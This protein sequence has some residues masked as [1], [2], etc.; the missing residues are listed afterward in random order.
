[1]G[2]SNISDDSFFERLAGSRVSACGPDQINVDYWKQA[3]GPI[4]DALFGV[5]VELLAGAPV[6]AG[7][8]EAFMVFLPKGVEE[9]DAADPLQM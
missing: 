5:L 2:T 4:K 8:N 9:G 7:F 3:P 1:M 6:P